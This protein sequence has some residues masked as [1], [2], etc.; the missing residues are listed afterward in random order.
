MFRAPKVVRESVS[1]QSKNRVHAP[2][3]RYRR[4]GD[5]DIWSRDRY[6]SR[7]RVSGVRDTVFAC[8]I[9]IVTIEFY[10]FDQFVR[11][12]AQRLSR[13]ERADGVRGPL[14]K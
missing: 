2:G 11:V 8:N 14:V 4:V 5:S 3:V 13:P 6:V 9:V 12:S 7:V 1:R 10:V